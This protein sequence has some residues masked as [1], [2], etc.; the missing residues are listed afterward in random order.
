[1]YLNT[2]QIKQ[3]ENQTANQAKGRAAIY[4]NMKQIFQSAE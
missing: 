4:T 1:M 2:Q 3:K